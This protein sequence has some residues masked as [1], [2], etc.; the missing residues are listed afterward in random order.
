MPDEPT[1]AYRVFVR[2]RAQRVGFRLYVRACAEMRGVSGYVKNLPDGRVEAFVQGPETFVDE[3]LERIRKGPPGA[4][5]D[6]VVVE[7]THLSAVADAVS[8]RE[9]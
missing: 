9:W 8:I 6:E 5:V 2:G 1:V 7:R 3:M 4:R